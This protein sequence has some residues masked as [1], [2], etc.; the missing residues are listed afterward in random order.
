MTGVNPR[1]TSGRSMRRGGI[2]T[3]LQQ[4]V[5]EGVM[6]A[7]LGHGRKRARHLYGLSLHRGGA[8]A[9]R[10]VGRYGVLGARRLE[11]CASGHTGEFEKTRFTRARRRAASRRLGLRCLGIRSSSVGLLGRQLEWARSRRTLGWGRHSVSSLN[12]V[13]GAGAPGAR[14]GGASGT[15]NGRRRRSRRTPAS[16]RGGAGTVFQGHKAQA[17]ND[18]GMSC[19]GDQGTRPVT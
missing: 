7:S 10:P 8:R 14:V 1:I 18:K 2:T 3:A 15:A 6:Y 4:K 5:S 13:H 17:L 16:R 12:A 19:C 11:R 9:F